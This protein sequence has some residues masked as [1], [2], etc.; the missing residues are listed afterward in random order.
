ML[1]DSNKLLLLS[2][3]RKNIIAAVNGH[4]IKD[5]L[6]DQK[7][8]DALYQDGAVF[9]TL[10]ENGILRGCIGS[11]EA[12]RSLL[13]DVLANSYN[14]AFEDSRFAKVVK[15]EMKDVEIEISLLSKRQ[16]VDYYTFNDLKKKIKPKVHGVYLT[17][18]SHRATFLP[19]VWDELVSHEVFFVHLAQKAGLAPDFIFNNHPKIEVYTVEKFKEE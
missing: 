4:D 14:A 19:Q 12:Y 18:A 11:L 7:L 6:K 5:A 17:Y 2:I 10:S 13:D 1:S 8:P 15:G 3:A 9:V 16:I